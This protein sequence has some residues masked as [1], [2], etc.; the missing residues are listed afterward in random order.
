MKLQEFHTDSTEKDLSINF[1][2]F[3]DLEIPEVSLR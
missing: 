1:S 2:L 3:T